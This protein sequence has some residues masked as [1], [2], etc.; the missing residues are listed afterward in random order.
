MS[1]TI[2]ITVPEDVRDMVQKANI[3]CDARRDILTYIMANPNIEISDERI[4]RYQKEYDEKYFAFEEAK[5]FIEKNYVIPTTKGK[6]SNWFLNYA[7]CVVTITI[8]E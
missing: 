2:E 7:S 1:K 8:D 6:A 4:K 3:E 5:S